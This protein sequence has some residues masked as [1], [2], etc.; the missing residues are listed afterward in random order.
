EAPGGAGGGNATG[1]A[2][3]NTASVR[4]PAPAGVCFARLS[5]AALKAA[6]SVC[7]NAGEDASAKAPQTRTQPRFTGDRM[8]CSLPTFSLAQSCLSKK[9]PQG[10]NCRPNGGLHAPL[11]GPRLRSVWECNGART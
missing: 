1:P 3:T 8:V 7:A 11:S 4:R 10:L 2:G 6:L 9:P 5:H